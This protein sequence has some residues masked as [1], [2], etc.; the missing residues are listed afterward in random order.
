MRIILIFL[1]IFTFR[2]DILSQFSQDSV[3]SYQ[4]LNKMLETARE[5]KDQK[6]LAQVY[7]QLADYEGDVFGD[8]RRALEYYK[9][10]LDYFKVTGDSVRVHQ[11]NFQIAQRYL[12]T[13]FVDE[14]LNILLKL[15][16][17]HAKNNNKAVLA[18]IYFE[19]NKVYKRR[20]EYEISIDYLEKSILLNKV[21]KDTTLL[22]DILFEKISSF[23]MN[24]DLDSAIVTAY[25]VF[26]INTA[27]KNQ[28]MVAK[29]LFH[30][31]YINKLKKDYPK[32]VK[33]LHKSEI[34]LPFLPYSE[35]RKS[36]YKELANVYSITRDYAQGYDYLLKYTQLND[37][38]LN[39]TRLE[40]IN[41]LAL[42]Y[43]SKD[44]QS[45]IEILKIDKLNAEQQ[46]KAQ[47]KTLYILAFGLIVVLGSIYFI[48]KFYD[49]RITSAKIIT[50]QTE[51]I[52]HQKIRELEDN[53]KM[54]SM[55]S[56]IEGQEIERERI[57][58]DLHD[59]LGG[60]LSTIK[61]Q[62]D[63]VRSKQADMVNLKEYNQ[64]YKL[65]DTAVEEVRTISR[66]L[67]PGSLQD[68]GLIPAIKDLINRFEGD[69]YPDIYFQY[70]E[71]PEKI[72]KMISLSIYRVIQELLNNS[73]KHANAN[74]ILIQINTED[75]ELVIQYEDDGVG[76][77]QENL[78]RKG[79]GLE[80]I[81][82]RINYMHGSIS[83]DS[84]SGGGISV[85]IRIKHQ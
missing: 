4:E 58:K 2:Q 40:S 57:A 35:N 8:Y 44:K 13:G 52:N 79:M 19:I 17:V 81:K 3:Y 61:L 28:Q 22:T 60:L 30:I 65:L 23:E 29:S 21:I 46:N 39:K 83:I 62:F 33:Y 31:G 12:Q 59:S 78:V 18:K 85:L 24:F 73:L 67:Q 6:T 34:L 50:K 80:N 66:N 9:W 54:S 71:M 37:S 15:A 68:L 55:I 7:L 11:T 74:E 38:I 76:F 1:I 41:N 27:L 69:V 32:A 43:G 25:E 53:M 47:Q 84:Q 26:S 72:D 48:I 10:A 45:S 70:Y 64:A 49:Q 16:E 5:N 14:S 77:D 42:K 75:D 51:E 56:V 63:H 36:I 82:S 20:G